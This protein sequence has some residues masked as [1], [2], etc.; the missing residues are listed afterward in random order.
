MGEVQGIN[1]AQVYEYLATARMKLFDWVRPLTLEQYTR[2]FPFGRKSVRGTLVEIATAEWSYNRRLRGED[3]RAV[4]SDRPFI[5]FLNTEFAP[6]ERAWKGQAEETRNTLRE[7]TDWNK[8]LEYTPIAGG[9]PDP[10]LRIRTTTGGIAIQLL[11]HEIHHRAQAMAILKQL[12]VPAEN[13][14]YSIL[15]FQRVAVPA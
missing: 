12:G 4:P 2:E 9:R 8:Q 10:T 11:F 6:L 5:K 13:L 15:T 14:D 1:P 7:I 3:M